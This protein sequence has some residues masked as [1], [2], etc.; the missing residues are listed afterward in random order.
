MVRSPAGLRTRPAEQVTSEV[1]AARPGLS[2]LQDPGFGRSR[3]A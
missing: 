1:S 3:W 2:E